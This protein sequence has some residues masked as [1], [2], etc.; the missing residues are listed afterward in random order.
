[1][2]LVSVNAEQ[3]PPLSSS[4]EDFRSDLRTNGSAIVTELTQALDA[5]RWV[6][7]VQQIRR[8]FQ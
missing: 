5:N 7:Y 3:R 6:S 4:N 8:E 1:M 2:T